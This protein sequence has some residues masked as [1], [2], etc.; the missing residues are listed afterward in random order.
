MLP[1]VVGPSKVV[2][3]SLL[4]PLHPLGMHNFISGRTD[5]RRHCRSPVLLCLQHMYNNVGGNAP[6]VGAALAPYGSL[7]ASGVRGVLRPL[8]YPSL[9]PEPRVWCSLTSLSAPL[10]P[11]YCAA[12]ARSCRLLGVL[13][14]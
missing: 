12:L 2:W 8:A 13:G 6:P 4:W 7:G 3:S 9:P 10:L 1:A 5:F 11:V 14:P